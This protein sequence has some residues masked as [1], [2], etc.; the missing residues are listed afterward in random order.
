MQNVGW[1]QILVAGWPVL[2]VLTIMSIITLAAVW[3]RWK[4]FSNIQGDSHD[5]VSSVRNNRDPQKIVAFC[6]KSRQPL[7]SPTAA[8]FRA[9]ST[10]DDKERAMS[11]SIQTLVQ[12]C[13]A[14]ISLLA[15]IASVAPFVGLLGTVIGI[16]RAF[17]AVSMS[18]G[19]ASLVAIRIS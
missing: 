8:I 12:K 5:F 11:R 18:S 17:R 16:I 1:H 3:E 15:T 13:E 19:G 6:E 14:N 4:F 7:A 9:S 10:R 2:S